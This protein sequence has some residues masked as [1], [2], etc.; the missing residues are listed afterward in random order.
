MTAK[1]FNVIFSAITFIASGALLGYMFT[2]RYFYKTIL[3]YKME[4]NNMES[5][6]VYWRHIANKKENELVALDE[7]YNNQALEITKLKTALKRYQDE[8][9][10]D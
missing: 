4:L 1:T 10:S 8:N 6:K 3:N 9:N 5:Q 7:D 2:A